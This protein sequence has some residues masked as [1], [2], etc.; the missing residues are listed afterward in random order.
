MA[1]FENYSRELFCDDFLTSWPPISAV[2]DRIMLPAFTERSQTLVVTQ[3]SSSGAV[4]VYSQSEGS[5]GLGPDEGAPGGTEST[6]RTSSH[7]GA[8][9]VAAWSLIIGPL[10]SKASI[11]STESW[12]V[13]TAIKLRQKSRGPALRPLRP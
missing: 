9:F 10:R 6:N 2:T 7:F 13:P 1:I 8:S 4:Q 12:G 3:R 11:Q 5:S